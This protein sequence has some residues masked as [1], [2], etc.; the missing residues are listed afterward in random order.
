MKKWEAAAFGI[1]LEEYAKD[2]ILRKLRKAPREDFLMKIRKLCGEVGK[3]AKS[4]NKSASKQPK[5]RSRV[6][7]SQ[8]K[9]KAWVSPKR[10]KQGVAIKEDEPV[11]RLDSP[12]AQST[13][14][15]GI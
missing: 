7:N 5:K 3:N 1:P 15:E 6:A 8:P 9:R 12:I 13:S 11:E 14:T 4:S 2:D 10:A